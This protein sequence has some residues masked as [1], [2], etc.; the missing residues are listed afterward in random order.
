M[1]ARRAPDGQRAEGDARFELMDRIVCPV[2]RRPDGTHDRNRG[3]AGR[4]SKLALADPA[5]T[6][7]LATAL[8]QRDDPVLVETL[9]ANFKY[10]GAAP[11]VTLWRA[12]APVPGRVAHGLAGR[13]STSCSPT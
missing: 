4:W 11:V 13:R 7:R 3:C 8:G 12:L 10:D 9:F 5:L 1:G 2:F 6:T